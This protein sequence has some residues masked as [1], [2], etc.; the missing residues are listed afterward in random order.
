MNLTP[1]CIIE[2]RISR[3]RFRVLAIFPKE[4]VVILISFKRKDSLPFEEK[5]S[6][7]IQSIESEDF[8]IKENLEIVILPGELTEKQQK[9]A[10]TNWSFIGDFVT[11]EP[12]CFD[13]KI[14]SKFISA[15]AIE[16]RRSRKEIQ[17][18]LYQYWIGGM[19]KNALIP[20]YKDRGGKGKHKKSDKKLGRPVVYKND[21]RRLTIGDKEKEQIRFVIKNFYNDNTKYRLTYAYNK[22]I[23]IYYRDKETGEYSL[24]YPTLSQFRYHAQPFINIKTRSGSRKYNKDMRGIQGSSISEA[25]GPGDKYQI[26]ATVGDVYLVSRFDRRQVI[27]R[28]VIYFVTDV[29]SRMIAGFYV[30]LEGPS[31]IGAMMAILYTVMDKVELCRQFEEDIQASMW[32]CKGLP[33]VLMVDNGELIS[34]NSNNIIEGLGIKVQNASAWRPDMKGIVEQSFNLLNTSTKMILPGA[35][36]PDFKERGGKDY[37]LDA[38]LNIRDFTRIIIKFIL[39]YNQRM[40]SQHPQMMDDVIIDKVPAIPLSLWDWGISNRSGRLRQMYNEDVKVALL[41]HDTARVTSRGIKFENVYFTCQTAI[42]EDWFSK[43]RIGRTWECNIAYDPRNTDNIYIMY[44]SGSYELCPRT[45]ASRNI[46]LGWELE[47]VLFAQAYGSAS[48]AAYSPT[49]LR[50]EIAF[51]D[52]VESIIQQAEKEAKVIEYSSIKVKNR[53]DNI[54]VNRKIERDSIRKEETFTPASEIGNIEVAS[55][56]LTD[57][58]DSGYA[59]LV[60][61]LQEKEMHKGD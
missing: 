43:A 21:N 8:I 27:G 25:R 24:A 23:S 50:N 37:R 31:W 34:K 14:R 10:E 17:R 61:K 26:D 33:K 44:N 54:K 51:N 35:I 55:R 59:D 15:K 18:L 16:L 48:K 6:S 22:L 53:I 42:R 7:I 39:R 5:L 38:L 40:L 60:A 2:N 58:D 47:E 32:P 36:L 9:V 52:S 29:F 19:T 3:E 56:V 20:R 12:A 45:E 57:D 49:V 30:G 4:D 46:Y 28:P 11:D 13:Q 41:P 1:N